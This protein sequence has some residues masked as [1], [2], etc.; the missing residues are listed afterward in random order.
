MNGPALLAQLRSIGICSA[1]DVHLAQEL[2]A[3][4]QEPEALVTL[5]VALCSRQTREGHVCT[6]LAQLSGQPIATPE[7]PL[8][9]ELRWPSLGEWVR[10]LERSPLVSDGSRPTPLVFEAPD[11]LYLQRYWEHE[12]ELARALVRRVALPAPLA[13]SPPEQR[14]ARVDALFAKLDPSGAPN[15]QRL[16][17]QLALLRSL[18]VISGGPGTGKTTTVVRILALAIEEHRA[19]THTS[20]R[21]LLLAPTGKAAARLVESIK[22]AKANL[23]CAPELLACIPDAASTIH[24]T[25]R[26]QRGKNTR[27]LH[28]AQHPLVADIVVVDECSMVDIAL[29][30]RLVDAIP[31]RARLILLGDRDQ[32]ASVEAGAVF[33]DICGRN[34]QT[35]YGRE[36]ASEFERHFAE[37]LAGPHVDG[38]KAIDDAVAVLTHSYRFDNES[39][40]GRFARAVRDGDAG[41]ARDQLQLG[42]G[43]EHL[44]P[45]L[46]RFERA[47]E[48]EIID[49]YTPLL[50]S[51]S[52]DAAL[53]RFERFRILCANRKGQLGVE[54]MNRLAERALASAGLIR[55][56]VRL[57]SG[58]PILITS[59]DYQLELFNGD[60]GLIWADSD[61]GPARAYFPQA[62]GSTRVLSPARLPT[63]ETVFAMSIHKSQGSEFD[64]VLV[65]LP[66]EQSPLLTRELL[67]TAVTRARRGVVVA[68]TL[69]ALGRAVERRV[70]RAS[71]LDVRLRGAEAPKYG[72]AATDVD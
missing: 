53:L 63:H 71:G 2:T 5:A 16:A 15:A 7:G 23:P 24:R 34:S 67:Y 21:V 8:G 65:L 69:S 1:L 42:S 13:E 36:L 56:D 20:P 37:A 54:G 45:E 64:R 26:L 48:R 6:A 31:D 22:R 40:L 72:P 29:M 58:R 33:G 61:T 70:E 35:G 57:Y 19:L 11:R 52:P 41:A 25:L 47:L 3:L 59:N 32:L 39:T 46:P 68:A 14:R 55:P 28:D 4:A 51:T 30:R 60:V 12:V 17:A 66:G 62:D 50:T 10:A 49:G 43:V 9:Q 38:G 44:S 27:F 18:C